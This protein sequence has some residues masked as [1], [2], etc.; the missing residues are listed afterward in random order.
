MNSQ[1]DASAFRLMNE[2]GIRMNV[3]ILQRLIWKEYRVLRSF[4][5]ATLV[6]AIVASLAA[7]WFETSHL[8]GLRLS[9][10]DFYFLAALGSCMYAL[11]VGGMLF[12][13]EHE[14]STAAFLR[15][16]PLDGRHL[17]A[18]KLAAAV[19]SIL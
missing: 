10:E 6:L 8:W 3:A 14:L 5:L 17:L 13:I 1:P 18:S 7:C 2:R 11:G 4:W 16:L 15:R 19:I 12:A 9:G